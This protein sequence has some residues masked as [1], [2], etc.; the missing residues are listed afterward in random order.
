MSMELQ[1][2]QL[3]IQHS[4]KHKE[5]SPNFGKMIFKNVKSSIKKSV[6]ED[7]CPNIKSNKYSGYIKNNQIRYEYI[8]MKT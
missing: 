3:K 7:F 6:I 1:C 4:V 8:C 5:S 2:V